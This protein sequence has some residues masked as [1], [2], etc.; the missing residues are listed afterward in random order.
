MPGSRVGRL[1]RC[2]ARVAF[3]AWASTAFGPASAIPLMRRVGWAAEERIARIRYR[4]HHPAR[5]LGTRGREPLVV[6]S[7]ALRNSSPRRRRSR[8]FSD[9]GKVDPNMNHATV[10]TGLM[11]SE[12]L[13]PRRRRSPRQDPAATEFTRDSQA[14]APGPDDVALIS[15]QLTELPTLQLLFSLIMSDLIGPSPR[16]QGRMRANG[17]LPWRCPATSTQS[18]CARRLPTFR[19]A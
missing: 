19:A 13:P 18:A 11:G 14:D 12:A 7:C 10:V 5:Q 4:T 17:V 9:P 2:P 15:V 8:A 1:G 3:R 16:D 6:S